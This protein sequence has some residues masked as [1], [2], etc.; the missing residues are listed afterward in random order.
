MN[1]RKAHI[2]AQNG[3]SNSLFRRGLLAYVVSR[4]IYSKSFL[5]TF[6]L[7]NVL[8]IVMSMCCQGQ[9][10]FRCME[11]LWLMAIVI[12]MEHTKDFHC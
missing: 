4:S 10:I 11:M 8:P 1:R 9:R 7:E 3:N 5:H 6:H 12:Q 2:I